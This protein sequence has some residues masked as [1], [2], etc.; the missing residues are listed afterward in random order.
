MKIKER[1]LY[2]YNEDDFITLFLQAAQEYK[3]EFQLWQSGIPIDISKIRMIILPLLDIT[4]KGNHPKYFLFIIYL[5]T[6]SIMINM[7]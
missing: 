3:K 5:I 7:Q 6:R 1:S 2:T 4:I